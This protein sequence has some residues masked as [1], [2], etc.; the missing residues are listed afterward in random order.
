VVLATDHG[1]LDYDTVVKHARYVF[2]CRHR[3][4]TSERIESL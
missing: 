4:A 3:L 1:D 2:D